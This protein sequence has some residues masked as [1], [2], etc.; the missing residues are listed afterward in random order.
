ML[1]VDVLLVRLGV[2]HECDRRTDGQTDRTTYSNNARKRCTLKIRPMFIRHVCFLIINAARRISNAFIFC[3]CPIS[4]VFFD[5]QTIL[6]KVTR[7]SAHSFSKF[8]RGECEIWSKFGFQYE[9]TYVKYET[10]VGQRWWYC[11]VVKILRNIEIASNAAYRVGYRGRTYICGIDWCV[12]H[13]PVLS[14]T[15]AGVHSSDVCF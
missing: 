12:A 4:F 11:Y 3:C 13:W 15:L 2:D 14:S 7:H 1:L 5:T 8:Y 9:A 6:V 10:Q